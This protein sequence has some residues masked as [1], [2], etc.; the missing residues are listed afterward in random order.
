MIAAVFCL[1]LSACGSMSKDAKSLMN[2]GDYADAVSAWDKVLKD[3]PGDEEAQRLRKAAQGELFNLEL[4]TLKSLLDSHQ[5]ISGFEQLRQLNEKRKQWGLEISP[6]TGLYLAQ[7]TERLYGQYLELLNQENKAL[8][9]L[10]SIYLQNHYRAL[11]PTQVVEQ[12]EASLQLRNQIGLKQCDA[13]DHASGSQDYLRLYTVK[14]C[15]VFGKSVVAS[16]QMI[17]RL[18]DRLLKIPRIKSELGGLSPVENEML[19]SALKSAVTG[20]PEFSVQGT[21]ES[22]LNLSGL[23]SVSRSEKQVAMSHSYLVKIPFTEYVT[24]KNTR[25]HPYSEMENHCGT[26]GGACVP[27][28]VTKYHE[29]DEYETLTQTSYRD[30]PRIYEFTGTELQQKMGFDLQAHFTSP[31]L[32]LDPPYQDQF[33]ETLQVH[34]LSMPEIGLS[35]KPG[36]LKTKEAFFASTVPKLLGTFKLQFVKWWLDNRC[37][38]QSDENQ[39]QASNRVFECLRAEEGRAEPWVKNWFISET[40]L[41]PS[42]ALEITGPIPYL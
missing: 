1:V 6:N 30:E 8:H 22:N 15:K 11:L 28:T 36:T 35:P 27:Q 17:K 29:V 3:N 10:K 41:A 16:S 32:A 12:E 2:Q 9:P 42:E 14:F 7:Q 13:L 40:G 18:K 33:N 26:I 24:V 19:A 25:S 5:T 31:L 4:V 21:L 37:K 20:F 38:S 39:F 23:L 34:L